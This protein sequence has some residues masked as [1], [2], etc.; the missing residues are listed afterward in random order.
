[1]LAAELPDL[2]KRTDVNQVHTD[3]AYNSP[4][5]D[6]LMREHQIEQIQT[7]IRGRKPPRDKLGLDDFTWQTD[8]DGKPQAVT[9]PHGQHVPVTSGRKAHRFCATFQ[10]PGCESCSRIEQCPTKQLK[11][12]PKRVLRF[13][14]HQVDLALRRQ[15]SAQARASGQDLRAAVEATVRSVKHPFGNGKVPVRGKPRVSMVMLGSALMSNLRRIHRYLVD[16]NRP[17]E[18]EKVAEQRAESIHAQPAFSFSPPFQVILRSIFRLR[19]AWA[20]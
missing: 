14:Q 8:A 6:N 15:R 11:R 16:Q 3:G 4:E 10:T 13:S 12:K 20:G 1:M 9:C 7:A 19:L 17:S 18:A 5:V 2:I